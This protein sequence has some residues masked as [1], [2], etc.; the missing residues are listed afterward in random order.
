[1]FA[2]LE[3]FC[4]KIDLNFETP[5]LN[6]LLNDAFK[7][8]N[9]YCMIV[10][11]FFFSIT[12]YWYIGNYY[13][14]SNMKVYENSIIV[15][16][17]NYMECVIVDGKVIA[18]DK[19]SNVD[20]NELLNNTHSTIQLG[21]YNILDL[22][23]MIIIVLVCIIFLSPISMISQ[24]G[25]VRILILSTIMVWGAVTLYALPVSNRGDSVAI[26]HD[27]STD[28]VY[29]IYFGRVYKKN[30]TWYVI[31]SS[32]SGSLIRPANTIH[33]NKYY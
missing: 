21:T 12:S 13:N 17:R 18:R 20:C 16:N 5:I 11:L 1:M 9:I 7:L 14:I 4:M 26:V 19:E 8:Y 24:N 32:L 29:S 25:L 15:E 27:K 23:L 10:A 30:N 28:E 3:A 6:T 22:G 31:N 2:H 33:N